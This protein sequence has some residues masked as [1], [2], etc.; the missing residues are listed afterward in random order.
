MNICFLLLLCYNDSQV[1]IRNDS[2]F[3][4]KTFVKAVMCFVIVLLYAFGIN[5]TNQ[6]LR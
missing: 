1:G 6:V 5:T 2:F 3:K 4:K